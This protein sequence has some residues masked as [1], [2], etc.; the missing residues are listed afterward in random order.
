MVDNLVDYQPRNELERTLGL[1]HTTVSD[2]MGRLTAV[3]TTHATIS[4]ERHGIIL[5]DW[6]RGGDSDEE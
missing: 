6:C 4:A 1:Q 3:N 2:F 5:V